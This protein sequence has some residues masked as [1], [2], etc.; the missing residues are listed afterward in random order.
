MLKKHILKSMFCMLGVCLFF[1]CGKADV[2]NL[3]ETV[4]TPTNSGTLP[5]K[6]EASDTGEKQGDGAG[7]QKDGEKSEKNQGQEAGVVFEMLQNYKEK[8]IPSVYMQANDNEFYSNV[9]FN[10]DNIMEYYTVAE[11]TDGCSIWKYTLKEGWDTEPFAAGVDTA[12]EREA[13]SW[14]TSVQPKISHARVTPFRGEDDNDYAWY[15]GK[16]EK[17]HLVKRTGES[18]VEIPVSDWRITEQATVAVLANGNIVSADAGKECFVYDQ[19]DGSQLSSFKCGWYESICVRENII[20]ISTRG[21]ADLQCYDAEKQEFLPDI[22]AGFQNSV[23]VAIQE[24][25]IYVCTPD[26]IFRAKENSESI[27]KIMDAG[28]FHFA[29]ETGVLLKFFVVGDAFYIVYG[30][31]KGSIKK[32]YPAGDGNVASKTLTVYSLVSNDLILDLVSEFQNQYPDIQLVYETGE[33]AG[34]SITTADRIRAL[35]TRILAGNGPDVF[36][37]DG[38]VAESYVEK[39]I[40]EDLTPVL[41]SLK[42]D[43]L[44]NILSSYTVGDKIY[45]LPMRIMIPMFMTSGQRPE[46][47][48]TLE[49]LVEYSE[50]EGG[51]TNIGYT[52][53]DFLQMLYYNY[54]PEII[55]SD[56]AVNKDAMFQFLALVKRFCESEQAYERPD[57]IGT[58]LLHRSW[59]GLSLAAGEVDFGFLV[60][61]GIYELGDN[62][63]AVKERGGELVSN[64]GIFFPNGL[65]AVNQ[66]SQE[67]ECAKQLLKFAFSYEGQNRSDILNGYPIHTGILGEY[68]K[69]DLSYV[70]DGNSK[71]SLR[72]FTA[73]EAAQMIQVVR[74]VRT[75]FMVDGSMW[76]ILL[77]GSAGYLKG[78]RGL[79]ETV[80][81]IASALQLYLYEQ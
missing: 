64:N 77:E 14:L 31:D 78:G 71:I 62:P 34:G 18:C 72:E 65:L 27:Q 36:L 44:P 66:F 20:Y 74:E 68:A 70:S 56:G 7:D 61:D 60:G 63:A 73:E 22:K 35:N 25:D 38:L 40:L 49:A 81:E 80:E 17:A 21:G 57:W 13:V 5:D 28:T 37:L 1:G 52:A 51:V 54:T 30:E 41:D 33:G 32:Y 53:A 46:V 67:K 23:R 39:G 10:E 2:E 24:N 50:S 79:E 6:E 12:W 48:S 76:E 4:N 19:N 45:M 43:L 59:I 69:M 16:E 8:N 15:I 58:Y 42:E 47:Y 29:K 3:T 26:G 55:T 9:L 75:P 11:E